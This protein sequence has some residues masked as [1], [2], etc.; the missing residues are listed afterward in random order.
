MTYIERKTK[1]GMRRFSILERDLT[2]EEK[3]VIA[4]V[5]PRGGL[6][7]KLHRLYLEHQQSL[8][9]SLIKERLELHF[10]GQLYNTI[11]CINTHFSKQ[12]IP[13]VFQYEGY[14][15]GKGFDIAL[16][17]RRYRFFRIVPL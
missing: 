12:D 8:S 13:F 5:K 2:D 16:A 7:A 15:R 6:S 17:D 11:N 3:A 14:K 9:Y 4:E 1:A 10:V